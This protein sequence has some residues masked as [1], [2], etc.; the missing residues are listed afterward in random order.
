MNELDKIAERLAKD[1]LA[2]AHAELVKVLQYTLRQQLETVMAAFL[3]LQ[4]NAPV[5]VD[6]DDY[7]VGAT[8]RDVEADYIKRVIAHCGG[9][10]TKAC[11]ILGMRRNTLYGKLRI[12][13]LNGTKAV[14]S[15]MTER[16]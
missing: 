6:G 3:N 13:G 2:L 8:L 5:A 11:K 10:K 14:V 7:K 16:R 12:L 4:G 15:D 1:L 9:N